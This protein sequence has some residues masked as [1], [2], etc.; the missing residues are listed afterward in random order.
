MKAVRIAI[1]HTAET[2]HPI[3]SL[4]CTA[5]KIHRERVLYFSITD[6]YETVI[7]YVEG[8]QERYEAALAG[9]DSEEQKVYSASTDGCYSYLRNELDAHNRDLAMV[10][11]CE[12][13]AVI[14]PIEYLPDRRMLVSL[15]ISPDDVRRVRT[16]I[17]DELSLEILSV[18]AVPQIS[19]SGLTATQR[20]AIRTAWEHGYYEIPREATLEEIADE[21]GYAVSTVSDLLRR[22]QATLV[23]ESLG[24][25]AGQY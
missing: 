10:F 6:G 20:R 4:V 25:N 22:G 7:N 14:P 15:V 12:T 17:P 13:I 19:Q 3:H 18:G 24:I 1:T 16:E 21:L 8:D 5:P 9:L 23:R 2:I 11:Q